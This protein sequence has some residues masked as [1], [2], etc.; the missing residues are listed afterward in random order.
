M[1]DIQIAV[2]KI[3]KYATRESGD[4]VEVVERPHGGVTVVL[5]D[6]Q[7]S[8]RA[9]KL[10]SG[11]VA[12]KVLALIKDGTRDGV[13]ARAA[14]DYLY[15]QR[16]GKV[17]A[18]L[19]LCSVDLTSRTLV[20]SRNSHCP[21][22]VFAP[23]AEGVR[24]LD[25]ESGPIG[26]YRQTR[27]LVVELPLEP[28]IWV[29][30]FSD[31]ILEAGRRADKSWDPRAVL[32]ALFPPSAPLSPP[33]QV[34]DGLLAAALDCDQGRPQDD[35]SVIVLAVRPSPDVPQV[36]TLDMSLPVE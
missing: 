31:G 16:G 10:I 33:R 19:A 12:G 17:S 6:G 4:T 7:G 32:T 14:H 34:A 5:V 11:M 2:S 15:L 8:G 26:L 35:M 9:S 29:V 3:N 20:L 36:R 21:F 1:L 27:P 18:T 23:D 22:A 28:E 30:A 24:W 13:V 25:A